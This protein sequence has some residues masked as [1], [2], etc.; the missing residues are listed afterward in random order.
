MGK[1]GTVKLGVG[2]LGVLGVGV[3]GVAVVG[4]GVDAVIGGVMGAGLRGGVLL[5]VSFG[6]EWVLTTFIF[7]DAVGVTSTHQGGYVGCCGWC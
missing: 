7:K 6:R 1:P 3:E 4:L 5:G 2:V